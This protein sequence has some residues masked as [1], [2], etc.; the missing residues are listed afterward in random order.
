MVERGR[1]RAPSLGSSGRG[2]KSFFAKQSHLTPASEV[3]ITELC[4]AVRELP[5]APAHQIGFPSLGHE[6]GLT[7]LISTSV[8]GA[9]I[10]QIVI[11]VV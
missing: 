11:A 3:S 2:R 8:R 6:E 1:K 4:V 10:S 5:K 7:T 9:G